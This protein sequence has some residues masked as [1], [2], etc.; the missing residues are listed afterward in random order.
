MRSQ[1]VQMH[2]KGVLGHAVKR[3]LR[4]NALKRHYADLQLVVHVFSRPH[5]DTRL[6]HTAGCERQVS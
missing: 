4:K 5:S 2:P 1:A 3:N 6:T